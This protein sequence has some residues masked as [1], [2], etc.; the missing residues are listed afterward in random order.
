MS[1]SQGSHTIPEPVPGTFLRAHTYSQTSANARTTSGDLDRDT[2][3]VTQCE[4]LAR[5]FGSTDQTSSQAGTAS[6]DS[7]VTWIGAS[8]T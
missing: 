7:S 8:I 2:I 3:P 6:A 4:S 5:Y 1:G